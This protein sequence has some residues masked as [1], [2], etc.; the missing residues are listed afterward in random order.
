MS[1][2]V[3]RSSAASMARSAATH[4][5]QPA[6]VKSSAS[7]TR[8]CPLRRRH[9]RLRINLRDALLV[10]L[11]EH[12]IEVRRRPAVRL[13]VHRLELGPRGGRHAPGERGRG[14][15]LEL[16]ERI[17]GGLGVVGQLEGSRPPGPRRQG[18][19]L[20]VGLLRGRGLALLLVDL[21][22]RDHAALPRGREARRVVGVADLGT[23]LGRRVFRRRF[24]PRVR[25]GPPFGRNP[26]RLVRE[27]LERRL[28]V[29]RGLVEQHPRAGEAAG[30]RTHAPRPLVGRGRALDRLLRRFL[31]RLDVAGG[32]AREGANHQVLGG[33]RRSG[34]RKVGDNLLQR[35]ELLVGIRDLGGLAQGLRFRR[36]RGRLRRGRR[37]RAGCAARRRPAATRSAPGERQ[38]AGGGQTS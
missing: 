27:Q 1:F 31:E 9:V 37:R 34:L 25:R 8:C 35:L 36:R 26:G 4:G 23:R 38:A 28:R 19:G 13:L 32:L 11:V 22:E 5:G 7:T 29:L 20:A 10:A 3:Y 14:Q 18:I 16:F 24:G 33:T 6:P 21:R 2:G 12:A 17:A 15:V 30:R